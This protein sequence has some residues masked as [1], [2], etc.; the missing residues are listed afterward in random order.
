MIDNRY[1]FR[2]GDGMKRSYVQSE[3]FKDELFQ[4][5]FARWDYRTTDK[6]I[7]QRR[8]QRFKT[9]IINI[10]FERNDKTS[11][12]FDR[13]K[14]KIIFQCQRIAVWIVSLIIFGGAIAILYFTNR[15]AFQEKAKQ[16][17]S[18]G[19][20][21]GSSRVRDMAIGYL[22]SAIVS[23]INLISQIVFAYIRNLKL[24]TRT[25][26]VRHYLIR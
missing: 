13:A 24:Y 1:L 8:E 19:I 2:Y 14:D 16:E 17:M 5:I 15:F 21:T 26:A 7:A 11:F 20:A 4:Y 22:P 23:M 25:T 6:V 9:E 10:L 12:K 3:S 18:S